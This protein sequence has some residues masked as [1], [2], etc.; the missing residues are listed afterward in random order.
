[1]FRRSAQLT[2]LGVLALLLWAA[3]DLAGLWPYREV[4]WHFYGPPLLVT[5]GVFVLTL[6]AMV[7]VLARHLT[8]GHPG[9]RLRHVERQV[10]ARHG[11]V[12]DDLTQRLEDDDARPE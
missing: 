3:H 7:A 4:L 5:M 10:Q 9:Q 2:T 12:D 8:H 11:S 1:V 6:W